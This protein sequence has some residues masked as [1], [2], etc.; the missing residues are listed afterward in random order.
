MLFT[1]RSR[2]SRT[3][4][5]VLISAARTAVGV[6]SAPGDF[7]TGAV[8]RALTPPLHEVY[9]VLVRAGVLD[10]VD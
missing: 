5:A 2:W 8:T 6:V 4:T 1:C 10:I 3:V 9:A 7:W